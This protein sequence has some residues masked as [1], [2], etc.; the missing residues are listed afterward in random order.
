MTGAQFEY[1]FSEDGFGLFKTVTCICGD[2]IALT[3]EYEQP[4][5]NH[6]PFQVV[7]TDKETVDLV[8]MTLGLRNRPGMLTGKAGDKSYRVLHAYLAGRSFGNQVFGE[9]FWKATR[10]VEN[11]CAGS[12]ITDSE[13]YDL[14]FDCF[15]DVLY[16]EYPCFV[17]ENDLF[18]DKDS[19]PERAKRLAKKESVSF[20]KNWIKEITLLFENIENVT[21]SAET[22]IDDIRI[23]DITETQEADGKIR[24]LADNCK[25]V[26][27]KN[28]A[29]K[30]I[31]C[32]GYG[33]IRVFERLRI[34]DIYEMDLKYEDG[35]SESLFPYWKGFE[36][37]NKCQFSVDEY[38]GS[39][40]LYIVKNKKKRKKLKKRM[41][42]MS[43]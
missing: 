36:T 37:T 6:E 16:E 43:Q 23:T 41:K 24:K 2:Y 5:E 9:M 26:I 12:E 32:L 21:L 7:P 27:N 11:A 33:P 8:K 14:F 3:D 22:D 28:G 20:D 42:R 18:G 30:L 35:T 10:R 34:N 25:I 31:N 15:E 39:L 40:I 13:Q 17:K 38:D 1:C 19:N 4:I 29:D